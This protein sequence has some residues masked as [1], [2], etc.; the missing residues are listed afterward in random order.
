MHTA[1]SAFFEQQA[2]IELALLFGSQARG[3]AHTDSDID[4]AVQ[5]TQALSTMRKKQLI[6]GIA[7]LSGCAVELV[8]LR[9]VGQPIMGQI[10]Q[11]AQRLKGSNDLF[12]CLLI[13]NAVDTADFIPYVTRLLAQRRAAWTS[14]KNWTP[15]AAVSRAWY[16]NDSVPHLR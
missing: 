5:A 7:L 4:V 12:A 9:H 13:R 11:D 6:E 15:C 16:S 2:D 1:L 8:D 14:R 3:S 10:I